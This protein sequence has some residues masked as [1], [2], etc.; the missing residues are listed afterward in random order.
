MDGV[1]IILEESGIELFGSTA[2]ESCEFS[3]G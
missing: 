2:N 1:E 3:L